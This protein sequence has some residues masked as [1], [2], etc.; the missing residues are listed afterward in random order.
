[1]AGA[2]SS[3]R[4]KAIKSTINTVVLALIRPPAM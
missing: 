4:Q 3:Q 2:G 1:M